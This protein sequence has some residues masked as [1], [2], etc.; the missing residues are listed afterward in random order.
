MKKKNIVALIPAR[1]G[2]K[3]LKDKN[4]LELNK[5]PLI[6]YSIRSAIDSNI[7]SSV[8]C[9]TDSK[10][11]AKIAEYYGAYVPAIRPKYIS[12]SKSQDILWVK[13]IMNELQKINI[14]C[15]IFSILRP[16]SPFRKKSTIKRAFSLFL[17]SKNIDSLRAVELCSQ[18]PGKMWQLNKKF[19]SPIF[20]N[21]DKNNPFHNRQYADLPK[22]YV[23]NASLEIA[24]THCLK[25]NSI[26][27]KKIIPFFT[28]E[29]EGFDINNKIDFW[30]AKYMLNE[31]KYKLPEIK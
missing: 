27:G 17:K 18:H 2:S 10:K 16:T 26:S 23:Q 12:G 30:R 15:D 25:Q 31:N 8:I 21:Q 4:I 28:N 9:V 19:I 13:W 29:E 3:R 6:A 11:Y 5:H 24:W 1:K 14:K 20:K 22:V 7:F